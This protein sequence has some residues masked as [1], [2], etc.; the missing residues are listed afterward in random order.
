[1]KIGGL[2]K[3]AGLTTKTIRFYESDGLLPEPERTS[4]GYRMYSLE[5][6]E[7]LRFI[8]KAKRLRLS[9]DEIKSILRLHSRSEPTCGHVRSLIEAKLAQVDRALGDLREFR[10]QL[11]GIRDE[12]GALADC[13]PSGGRICGIIEQDTLA[14]SV[15]LAR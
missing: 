13:R 8:L 12:A 14:G 1:M 3:V 7:R 9:L 10:E 6:A 4:S 11:A 5:D 15:L 2:A